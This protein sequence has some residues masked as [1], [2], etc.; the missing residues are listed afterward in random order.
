MGRPI[1]KKYFGNRNLGDPNTTSD[2][3]GIG[4]EYVSAVAP[5]SASGYSQGATVSITAPQIP[6]GVQAT[7]TANGHTPQ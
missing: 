5:G 7:A 3:Y 2:D 1:Q 6:P 4:G